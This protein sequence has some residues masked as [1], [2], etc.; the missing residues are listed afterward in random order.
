MLRKGGVFR[1]RKGG[2]EGLRFRKGKVNVGERG[3][4]YVR[5]RGV[6]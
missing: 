3:R 6:M 5:E 4:V 1:V 2:R